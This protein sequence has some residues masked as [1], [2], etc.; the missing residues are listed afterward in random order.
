MHHEPKHQHENNDHHGRHAHDGHHSHEGGHD[1]QH[2]HPHPHEREHHHEHGHKHRGKPG[3]PVLTVR[4]AGGLSGDMM[5][6]G[7]ASLVELDQAELD[8]LLAELRLPALAGSLSLEERSVN[9]I[10]G[11]GARVTL[12][13]EHAHRSMA[14]IE[15]LIRASAMPEPA[16]ELSLRAFGLLAEAEASVHG[17]S[18]DDVTFHEVGALDSILDICL[19]CRIFCLL[20]PGRFIC[21]PLPLADGSINCAHGR[22]PSPAPAVLR[23]LE[24][25]PVRGFAGEGETVTPTAVALLK[26]LG[27]E[28][29]L[30]PE[31]T[32]R[33]TVISYGAKVFPDLPN[34][35]IWALGS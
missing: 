22:I 27:A 7:L 20:D 15:K 26:A 31:F 6:S 34:G 25:V 28:F 19:V 5:L 21:S 2:V 4:A 32:V 11:W 8:A 18:R 30:W 1:H 13:P 3:R 33:K 9:A 10:G 17:K 35:A 29:G 14:D 24:G 12:P 23:L 16:M